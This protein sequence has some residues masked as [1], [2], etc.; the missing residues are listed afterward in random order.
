MQLL[1]IYPSFKA[2]NCKRIQKY[3]RNVTRPLSTVRTEKHKS[4]SKGLF[5][6]LILQN[7]QRTL[8]GLWLSLSGAFSLL[9]TD[10]IW[11]TRNRLHL[12]IDISFHRRFQT[13]KKDK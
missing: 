8:E 11:N 7:A 2:E 13:V 5:L 4:K 6:W 9:T 3:P 12:Y 1:Q 10:A